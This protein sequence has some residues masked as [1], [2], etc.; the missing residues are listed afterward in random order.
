MF[1]EKKFKRVFKFLYLK[2][3]GKSD[4]TSLEI[5]MYCAEQLI[6][7]RIIPCFY[8][9]HFQ[10]LSLSAVDSQTNFLWSTVQLKDVADLSLVTRSAENL[11]WCLQSV[12]KISA[13]MASIDSTL[14][15]QEQVFC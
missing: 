5:E 9:M 1:Q 8:I 13:E 3:L 11:G 4:D 15:F 14:G 6:L 10:E 12:L 2:K 7:K